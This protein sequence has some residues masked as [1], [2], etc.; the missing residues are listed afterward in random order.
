MFMQKNYLNLY[1]INNTWINSIM[2]F[3]CFKHRHC[4]WG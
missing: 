4:V 2:H 3:L 1:I